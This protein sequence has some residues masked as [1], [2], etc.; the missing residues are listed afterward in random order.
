MARP[1]GQPKL[2]GRQKGTPNKIT[3]TIK[4]ALEASFNQV[5]GA[6]YLAEMARKEPKAYMAMLGKAMPQQ[7]NANVQAAL[8]P[9]SIDDFLAPPP[10]ES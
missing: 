9:G 1:K 6:A 4:E 8:L 3:Q 10:P 5:G 7:I 2:G